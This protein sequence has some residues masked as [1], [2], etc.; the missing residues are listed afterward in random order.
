TNQNSNVSEQLEQINVSGSSENINVKEKK[1]GE[2]Q[3]SAKKLAKQ[4]ASDSRDLVRYETGI[5]VV[6]TG[7]T[8]ASGYAVRGVDEN[9]VGIMVDG[10]R[11]AE[12]LSSQGFKELFEGYGNFNNTRNSIE[13]ENVKTATITKGADS[14][15][16]GSGALG[17]SVIF[18]TKDA[19]D[20][21]I[22]KDHY[23][24]IKRATQSMNS[25]DT[26][27]L[28]AAGRYKGF[29]ALI[30]HTE[31]NSNEM[32][33][34]GYENYDDKVVGIKRE[35]TDPY[36][37]SRHSTLVKLGFEPTE[38]HRFSV[39][40]DKSTLKTDGQDLS[41]SLRPSSY[42]NTEI[43]Q[44]ERFIHD[45]SKRENIQFS[46]ENFTQTPFWDHFKLTYS[47]QKIKNKARS[48]EYCASANCAGVINPQGL[49]LDDSNGVYKILDKDN[50]E[51]T[52]KYN[53]GT[54]YENSRNEN[55]TNDI[56]ERSVESLSIDCDKLDCNKKF[57]VFSANKLN[58]K[59]DYTGNY[60]FED[61]KINIKTLPNGKKYG[62][63]ELDSRPNP[64]DSAL[65]QYEEAF[66]LLPKSEGY[67]RNDYNDRDLNT[68]TKQFNFD[69][70]KSF[71]VIKTEHAL[72]YGG[73]YSETEKSMV[74]DQGYKGGNVQWWADD[75]ICNK[76]ENGIRTPSPQYYP[77]SDC[78]GKLRESN[79]GKTSYLIPVKT[80]NHAF[81]LGDNFTVTNWLSFDLN[82]RYDNVRHLPHYRLGQD[83]E[84]PRGLLAGTMI[85]I[86]DSALTGGSG[87]YNYNHPDYIKN[88]QD[89]LNAIQ[90]STAFKHHSYNLGL[91][92]DPTD[93]LRIQF[94]YSNG[95]RAPTPDEMYMTF[96]HPQFSILPN[97]NLKEEKAKTKEIAFT[98]YRERSYFTTNLFQTD[99]KN[100]IDLAYLGERPIDQSKS[101]YYPFYQSLNRDKAKV[102]GIEISTHLE[103]GD[104]IEK[105]EGFHL[106]Y[107]LTYQKGRIKDSKP[108]EGYKK[109]LKH[110]PK[111]MNMV[112]Q[113]QPMNALQPT[114]SVYNLGY[115]SPNKIWGLDFYITDVSAKKAKD[116][117][118]P[119]WHSMIERQAENI[120]TG[121][122]ETVP[123][124]TV[125]GNEKV[126][127]RRALWRNKHYTV[128]D[129]IAYWKP[130]KNLTFT[131]GVYNL[132]NQKYLTWE[133]ARSIRTI[134]TINRIDT[135]TGIGLNRFYAPGRNYRMS[136]QFEF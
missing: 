37:I 78:T 13:I 62:Q 16:S 92:L 121:V 69:F 91:N 63:V 83:P 84:I 48:D 49:H 55:V 104:L 5:T 8:G 14:L 72:R 39:A 33:N 34:Y 4:Q 2:T 107:K 3:I 76:L 102:N 75:F 81:Y 133:S 11:Q 85:P 45:K 87:W 125:N 50:K 111:Y 108:L 31:R 38:N 123:A 51:L 113:D 73:L 74:N 70:D 15:K 124:K 115:D 67:S 82:Y 18:E 119:Q 101:S 30:V 71:S 79:L 58:G 29:D 127:D 47:S 6:E 98:F 116:S 25:Q 43:R 129:A 60:K 23:F 17:G 99:Y 122:I 77:T 12:T 109:L 1:V 135:E 10:L 88:V 131:A 21:L 112:L 7:R 26:V 110:N 96:K 59:N 57:R 35:K 97:T 93:W 28:T 134:G 103:I 130:I 89:N 61:R 64:F 20:Y 94:K 19:R 80:K 100:F 53:W 126:I 68:N 114:T 40:I 136:V 56:S 86:P 128:I 24:S 118:N 42:V 22:G 95:F 46:Y 54:I 66:Y 106:G 90:K 36:S 44:G 32:K 120:N 132:T 65:T 105:L 41:Y 9:R 117:F 52:G 27:S